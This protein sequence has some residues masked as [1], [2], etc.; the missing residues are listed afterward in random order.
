MYGGKIGYEGQKRLQDAQ[1]DVDALVHAVTHGVDD[2]RD[3][4]LRDGFE[5]DEA[6]QRAQ[7][8]CDD[9]RVLGRTSH[10]DGS[11]EVF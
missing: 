9:F 8:Y 7:R 3:R 6:L 4:R 1:L 5:R 11:K 2:D 10:K